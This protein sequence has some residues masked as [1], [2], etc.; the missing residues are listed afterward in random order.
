MVNYEVRV[1]Q[2][3]LLKLSGF[4]PKQLK[5]V[6]EKPECCK[7]AKTSARPVDSPLSSAGMERNI[8]LKHE[9]KHE[10]MLM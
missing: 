9:V 8:L 3:I 2:I 4:P 5:D 1:K 10:G 6:A 7:E